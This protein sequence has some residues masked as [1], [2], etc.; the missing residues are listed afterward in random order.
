MKTINFDLNG[1]F[2]LEQDVLERM[3]STYLDTLLSLVGYLGVPQVGSYI[4]SGCEVVG[5]NI[6]PGYMYI[7]GSLCYFAGVVGDIDTKI[8]KITV[9]S[10]ADFENATTNDVFTETYALADVSGLALGAFTRV[11]RF[12][13]TDWSVT[14][15]TAPGFLLNKPTLVYPLHEGEVTGITGA[16]T[17]SQV[18]TIPDVGTTNYKIIGSIKTAVSSAVNIPVWMV[19]NFFSD[20][21]TLHT[22]TL[23]GTT[24]AHTFE[25][26]IYPK[27]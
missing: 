25:Y 8:S 9:I 5:A 21:F 17:S 26:S 6:T 13:Q 27:P 11:K 24:P 12:E 7:D 22:Q 16:A 15:P 18:V 20:G 19:G 10:S 23:G 3:Q 14:D 1:G 4:L 2:P